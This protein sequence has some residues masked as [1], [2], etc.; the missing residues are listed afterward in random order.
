MSQDSLL[1]M[2]GLAGRAGQL[3]CG[4]DRCIE[5]VRTGRLHLVILD[6]AASA[7]T[8][9]KVGSACRYYHVP[10]IELDGRDVLGSRIGR[11]GVRVAGI[12]DGKLAQ[13]LRSRNETGAEV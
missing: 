5:A 2:L 1:G 10:L 8:R 6:G 4:Q 9:D 7:N 3:V 11:D 13:L 12:R